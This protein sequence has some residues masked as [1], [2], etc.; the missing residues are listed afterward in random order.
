MINEMSIDGKRRELLAKKR[1]LEELVKTSK[2]RGKILT[3]ISN[4]IDELNAINRSEEGSSFLPSIPGSRPGTPILEKRKS[5]SPL[6]E[7]SPYSNKK[8]LPKIHQTLR[9]GKRRKLKALSRR[10]HKYKK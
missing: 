10:N 8:K 3:K 5:E 2:N 9:G 7:T 1:K 4:I 6:S